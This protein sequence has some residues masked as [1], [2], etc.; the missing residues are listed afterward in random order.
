MMRRDFCVGVHG[1]T[2]AE[3]LSRAFI[4]CQPF[5]LRGGIVYT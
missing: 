5:E 2:K 3:F 1:S 4:A